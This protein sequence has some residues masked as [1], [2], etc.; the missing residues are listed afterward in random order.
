MAKTLQQGLV[1]LAK[2]QYR[3]HHLL[4]ASLELRGLRARWNF[5]FIGLKLYTDMAGVPPIGAHFAARQCGG[6]GCKEGH[7]LL[8]RPIRHSQAV[9][10]QSLRR[11]H[12]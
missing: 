2:A 8:H 5:S 1:E 4:Q 6:G 7:R 9:S 12:S 11:A 3:P 10:K